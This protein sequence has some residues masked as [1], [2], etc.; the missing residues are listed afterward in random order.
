MLLKLHIILL[1][2]SQLCAV[3]DNGPARKA[4][5]F[6][7]LQK[8]GEDIGDPFEVSTLR[9]D[10]FQFH[11][12]KAQGDDVLQ[13]NNLPSSRTPRGHQGP[14]AFLIMTSGLE[15]H[16]SGSEKPLKFSHLDIAGS[17]G[18]LPDD[19]TGAPVLA[20]ANLYLL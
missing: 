14:A 16:G 6:H 9:L 17:S 1:I 18:S 7:S 5:H 13:C 4:G 19:P 12:G 11:R 20:L 10:D 3:V 2:N 8:S 15:K